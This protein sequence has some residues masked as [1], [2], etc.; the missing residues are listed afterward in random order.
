M[1]DKVMAWLPALAK[2]AGWFTRLPVNHTVVTNGPE[3]HLH[4]TF[5][6]A[7]STQTVTMNERPTSPPKKKPANQKPAKKTS[8]KKSA[9]KSP[10][11]RR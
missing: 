7:P 6:E 4:Y 8:G 11:R 2:V 1:L 9:R 10:K 5:T 3:I